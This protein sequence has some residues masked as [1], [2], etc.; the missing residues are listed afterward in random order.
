[1]SLPCQVGGHRHSGSWDMFLVGRMISKD[2]RSRGHLT[3]WLGA[4]HGD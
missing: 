2:Q 4:S 3:L 1:M